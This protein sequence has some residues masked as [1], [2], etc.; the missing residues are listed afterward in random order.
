M[1]SKPTKPQEEAVG[2]MVP[3]L[4]KYRPILLKDIV[5]N[6][7]TVLRLQVIARDGN[8]P[9]LI[10]A[11]LPGIGKTTSVLCLAHELLGSA[12]KDAVLELNAS[13]ER[14]IDMVRD[15]IK[16]F[17]Q[18]KVTLP[19]G[20]HKIIILDEADSM[21]GG[22]QQALRRTM[23][24]YSNTTRFVFA[25]NQ[26][27]KIIEPIQSRCAILR[28]NKL[29]DAEVLS[30]LQDICKREN[31]DVTND[32]M[33][34][35]IFT[36]DGDMRQA[37]N[38]LQSTYYGF[39]QVNAQNVYKVCDEPH[40][41][42]LQ[43]ILTSCADGNVKEADRTMHDLYD[44]GYS[45]LDIITTLSRVLKNMRTLEEGLRLD[46]LKEIGLTHMRITDGHQS[47]LQL[48]G[49]IARLCR[50]AKESSISF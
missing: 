12:Y 38:N 40:P 20:R 19:Q 24:I 28:Y 16:H 33:E 25:C 26:S 29:T 14:G 1:D 23:E 49:M 3:W 13:D 15:R 17:A 37:I 27:N 11:G 44:L 8:M 34:A 6:Q 21:T 36:A 18:K 50:I 30:R 35:L 9:N 2:Y 45:S 7:D 22:A 31:V 48:S 32:G 39:K 41:A 47:V 5:G 10:L 42:V 4:E 43:R 46:L